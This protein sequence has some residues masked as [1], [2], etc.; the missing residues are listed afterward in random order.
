M[1]SKCHHYNLLNVM[2]LIVV[3]PPFPS[4]PCSPSHLL[5]VVIIVVSP[6]SSHGGY[7]PLHH[8]QAFALIKHQDF[9]LPNI[10]QQ[11]QVFG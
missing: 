7:P 8:C 11:H 6:S 9:L 10:H 5:R 3:P 1:V 4:P 2:Y